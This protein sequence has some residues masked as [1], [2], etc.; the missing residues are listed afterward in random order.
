MNTAETTPS[1]RGRD[2]ELVAPGAE[3]V[4]QTL[5][6]VA[7]GVIY[8]ALAAYAAHLPL[9]TRLPLFIWPAHGVALGTLLVAP[10]RRWPVYLALVFIATLAVGLDIG[11]SWPRIISTALIAVLQPLFVAT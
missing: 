4:R 7:F 6:F 8:Y 10:A 11:A 1:R 3:S 2:A 9:S 5:T